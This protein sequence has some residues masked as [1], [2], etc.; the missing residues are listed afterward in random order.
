LVVVVANSPQYGFGCTVAP[1]A[2]LSDGLFDVV[3]VPRIAVLQFLRNVTRLFS[4]KPLLGAH[5][6]RA[7]RI[8]LLSGGPQEWPLHLDGEP[9]G[10]T[11]A[12]IAVKRRAL[13]VLVP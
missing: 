10:T 2:D 12:T 3:C 9:G 6:Y 11:P 13:R 1:D 5:F 8:K 4:K 7:K